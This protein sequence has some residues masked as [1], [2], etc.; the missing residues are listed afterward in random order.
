MPREAKTCSH[1]YA[2]TYGRVDMRRGTCQVWWCSECGA[3]AIRR[4]QGGRPSR[5]DWKHVRGPWGERKGWMVTLR[6]K[7]FYL[8]TKERV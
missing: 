7:A 5:G 4:V 1:H 3:L 8:A 2:C 6:S